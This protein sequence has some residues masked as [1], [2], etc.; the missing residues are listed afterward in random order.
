M[1]SSP[2]RLSR[3]RTARKITAIPTVVISPKM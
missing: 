1:K 2:D 3:R